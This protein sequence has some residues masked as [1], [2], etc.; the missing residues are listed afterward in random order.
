MTTKFFKILFTIIPVICSSQVVINEV[1]VKP[2]TDP[3]SAVFQSLKDCSDPSRGYEYIELY[4]TSCNSVDIGCYFI[5]FRI[6]SSSLDGTFRF[7]A[8]TTIGPHGFISIGGANTG[9]TFILPTYCGDPHLVTGNNRWYIDNGDA[10]IA[11]YNSAGIPQDAVFWTT[12]AG[13]ASKWGTDSDLDEGPTYIPSPAGCPVV[14]SLPGP[15]SGSLTSVV[16]YAGQSPALGNVVHRTTDGGATWA[17]NGTPS[18]NA[19]NS[20]ADPCSLP[21][22]L[23]L[24]TGNCNSDKIKLKWT[25]ESE[26]NNDYFEI[27][28]SKDGNNFEKIAT[29]DGIGN[30]NTTKNYELDIDNRL[31]ET[32]YFRLKQLDFDGEFEYS[33]IIYVNCNNDEPNVKVING[34]LVI[35]N[36]EKIVN[37]TIYDAIGRI[38]YQSTDLESF[39]T[40]E[41]NTFYFIQIETVTKQYSFRLFN[42]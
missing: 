2:Q 35:S 1:N 33:N 26:T 4:N 36:I 6:F 16:G 39:I 19:T 22:E 8:G 17:N 15:T 37:C 32:G 24:F 31:F 13:Q 21:V 20:V 28:F 27:Q 41:Q 18:I 3:I 42:N 5:G 38:I 23:S 11:F 10:Y 29:V 34:Q 40:N 12:S 7:P 25:T 9:A 14:A 30:S